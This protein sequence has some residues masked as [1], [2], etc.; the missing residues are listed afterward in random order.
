MEKNRNRIYSALKR[1]V[2]LSAMLACMF[3]LSACEIDIP[4]PGS[5]HT[6][7]YHGTRISNEGDITSFKDTVQRGSNSA[8]HYYLAKDVNLEAKLTIPEGTYV[9]IC[10]RKYNIQLNGTIVN[11]SDLYTVTDTNNDGFIEPSGIYTFKC[12]EHAMHGKEMYYYV[13][14]NAVDFFADCGEN[15][16]S[17]IS[18]SSSVCNIALREN[19]NFDSN[20]SSFVIPAGKTLKVCTYGYGFTYGANL[21]SAGGHLI[22]INCLDDNYHDCLR[23]ADDAPAINQSNLPNVLQMMQG[24]TSGTVEGYLIGDISWTGTLSVPDGVTAFICLNGHSATG[25]IKT[26]RVIEQILDSETGLYVD[27]VV[28]YGNIFFFDCSNHICSGICHNGMM[29]ALNENSVDRTMDSLRLALSLEQINEPVFCVLEDNVDIPAIEGVLLSVCVNGFPMRESEWIVKNIDGQ[30]V[31]VGGVMY[32]NCASAH[33]CEISNMFGMPNSP[34]LTDT[35]DAVNM[36][37]SEYGFFNEIEG[38]DGNVIARVGSFNLT[39]DLKG[40]GELVAPEGT[41]VI[42]CLNGFSMGDVTVA[43][44]SNVFIYDC[45]EEYCE[46]AKTDVIALNQDIVNLFIIYSQMAGSPFTV[47]SNYI[48]ALNDDVTVPAGVFNVPENLSLSFCTHG[49]SISLGDALPNVTTHNGCTTRKTEHLCVMPDILKPM[50]P[51]LDMESKPLKAKSAGTVNAVFSRL[52]GGLYF[53]HLTEDLE[54]VGEIKAPTN[55]VIGICLDGYSAGDIKVASGSRI[56][57]YECGKHFCEVERT[58]LNTLDQN[59]FDF[60]AFLLGG[61]PLYLS[62]GDSIAVSENITIPFDI[63]LEEGSSIGIC[64]CGHN[65]ICTGGTVGVVLH[66]DKHSGSINHECVIPTLVSSELSAIPLLATDAEGLSDAFE[67]DAENGFGFYYLTANIVGGGELVLPENFMAAI[68][69]NGFTLGDL[70]FDSQ[71]VVVY[72]CGKRYCAVAQQ[73]IVYLDQGA[74]DFLALLMTPEDPGDGTEAAAP[75]F[76]VSENMIIGIKGNVT[77]NFNVTAQDGYKLDFC[78]CG[79]ALSAGDGVTFTNVVT[80]SNCL[81][82]QPDDSSDDSEIVNCP[83]CDRN[84][85]KPLNF[86]TLREII[87][88]D[89]EVTLAPGSYYYYLENDF[90]L[91]RMLIIPD[92]V[93]LHICLHG[94]TL[95]SAY[96][97]NDPRSFGGGYPERQS[98]GV[99]V[100]ESGAT[101]NIYDCSEKMTGNMGGKYLYTGEGNFLGGLLLNVVSD[102]STELSLLSGMSCIAIN[103]GTVNLYGGNMS[104][105]VG[106]INQD[107]GVLNIYNGYVDGLFAGIVSGNLPDLSETE[108][109]LVYLGEGSNVTGGFLGA[110]YANGGTVVLDGG[111]VNAPSTAIVVASTKTPEEGEESPAKV[112]INGGE[113]NVGT[114]YRLQNSISKALLHT[115]GQNFGFGN[116]DLSMD[117][118]EFVGVT[119]T[120]DLVVNGDVDIVMGEYTQG[121]DDNGNAKKVV[122]FA[123]EGNPEISNVSASSSVNGMY[124]LEVNTNESMD[125]GFNDAFIPQE[126]YMKSQSPDGVIVIVP[127]PSEGLYAD[128]TDMSV[129]TDGDIKVNLYTDIDPA[130]VNRVVFHVKYPGSTET[131]QYTVDDATIVTVNG[132]QKY[133]FS[134]NTSAKD[135]ADYI[136]CYFVLLPLADETA[137]DPYKELVGVYMNIKNVS[138]KS[139]LGTI[140]ENS[141]G[142]YTDATVLLAKAMENYCAAAAYHFGTANSYSVSAEMSQY[143]Q[144]ATSEELVSFKASREGDFANSPITF[145][146]ATLMLKSTTAIRIYFSV[147]KDFDIADLTV[148]IDGNA[149]NPADIFKANATTYYIDISGIFAADY[150]TPYEISFTTPGTETDP[151]TGLPTE[152]TWSMRYCVASYAYSVLANEASYSSDLIDLT[153]SLVIY[154][155][156][157]NMYFSSVTPPQDEGGAV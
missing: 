95:Y 49:H 142:S 112:I 99:A 114:G 115:C 81:P 155:T 113:I 100:V 63:K 120:H 30:D 135:Y 48:F 152:I 33:L 36:F 88:Y 93:D 85:A 71:S 14:Q 1:L 146:S 24:I 57:F 34:I 151:E 110:V 140:I 89:G 23:L 111:T 9:G 145:H 144:Q 67:R 117:T 147:P 12:G 72:E 96:I 126:G 130:V 109:T 143:M 17:R 25:D 82:A 124:T 105:F 59:A 4:S 94:Y 60:I 106:F 8:L 101:F 136:G 46:N 31:I 86:T 10:V 125:V 56:F 102:D 64:T 21:K 43:E 16:F 39:A 77:V 26:G 91:P 98:Y 141:E 15:I 134:I 84:S 11:D 150:F 47:N 153:K 29:Y 13:D 90:Q 6:C 116:T 55:A 104:A 133:M 66:D 70:E 156:F 35:A 118:S 122:D 54:G 38:S 20:S 119:V 19:L 65:V 83:V 128:L 27:T 53:Y 154:G 127:I 92:G 149:V 42:I 87:N 41:F 78:T 75:E 103:Y 2:C 5:D 28:N 139:Y 40:S 51:S 121:T 62:G 129:S 73:E 37:V 80:H 7:A 45:G 44:G 97:W 18:Q 108:D 131:V 107:G 148:K 58:N 138:I 61:N 3:A 123:V 68:C 50:D 76:L 157:A 132:V 79:A 137:D 32:Y 69:L 74:F 22:T 52:S